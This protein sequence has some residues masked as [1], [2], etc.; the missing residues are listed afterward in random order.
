M[1][2]GWGNSSFRA[3]FGTDVDVH[4]MLETG[5]FRVKFSKTRVGLFGVILRR[6]FSGLDKIVLHICLMHLPHVADMVAT[7]GFLENT[8]N[9]VYTSPKPR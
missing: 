9:I 8:N 1:L 4:Q 5:I 6:V 3:I 7:S 2:E